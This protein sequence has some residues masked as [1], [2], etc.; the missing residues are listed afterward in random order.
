[1]SKVWNLGY[2]QNL[3]FLPAPFDKLSVQTNFTLSDADGD[4]NDVLW[5]QQRG[6]A[7]KTFNF[8][9]GYRIGKWSITSSTNWTDDT[10]ASGLVAANGSLEPRAPRQTSIPAWCR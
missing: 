2:S 1:M 5:A 8:V 10:V 9:L 4:D 6:A 7:S 3:T